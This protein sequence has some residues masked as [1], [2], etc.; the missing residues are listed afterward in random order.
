MASHD[1]LAPGSVFAGSFRIV[2]LLG[3]GEMGATYVVDPLPQ[4]D[5]YRFLA[6]FS[7]VT[8]RDGRNTRWIGPEPGLENGLKRISVALVF[9][10]WFKRR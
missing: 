3:E 10:A 6:F 4:G 7:D 9:Q 5:Y 1:V 2:E 8:N